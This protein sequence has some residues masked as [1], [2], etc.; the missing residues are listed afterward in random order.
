MLIF[1][2]LDHLNSEFAWV[3]SGLFSL[4]P[5]LVSWLVNFGSHFLQTFSSFS[6]DFSQI[7]L[8]RNVAIFKP[9]KQWCVPVG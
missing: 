2:L 8:V 5:R 9:E 1:G 4:S 7:W 6:Y 3:G